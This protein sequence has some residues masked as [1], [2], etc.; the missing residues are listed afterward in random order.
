MEQEK[1]LKVILK[2]KQLSSYTIDKTDSS[3]FPKRHRFTLRV[4]MQDK[5]LDI[6]EMLM[7]ANR[8]NLS[9]N[10][11][12]RY[13]LQSKVIEE[14]DVFLYLIEVCM[15]K[16]IITGKSADYWSKLVSDVKYMTIA[17]RTKDKER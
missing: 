9:V 12:R 11:K 16:E 13:E 6:V 17:W 14:C 8:T 3:K 15:E 1:E 5:A 7:K 4:R 2:A 10:R